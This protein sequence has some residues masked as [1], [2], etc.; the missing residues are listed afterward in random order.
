MLCLLIFPFPANLWQP[1]ISQLSYRFAL[2]EC[3]IVETMQYVA[4]HHGFSLSNMYLRFLHVFSWLD[5]SDFYFLEK[6]SLPQTFFSL[7]KFQF[8]MKI[9]IMQN[10]YFKKC[11]IMNSMYPSSNCS[12]I[13]SLP[14][15]RFI[16]LTIN[17]SWWLWS[18]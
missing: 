2:S 7:E 15:V 9:F 10:I 17:P 6:N 13:S 12:Y 14:V 11:A 18:Q 3:S 5:S 4:F 8:V 1:V 16:Y